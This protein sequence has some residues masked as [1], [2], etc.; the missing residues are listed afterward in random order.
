MLFL[1]CEKKEGKGDIYNKTCEETFPHVHLCYKRWVPA[2]RVNILLP[3]HTH[4][5]WTDFLLIRILRS[6]VLQ[7]QPCAV[8]WGIKA[9]YTHSNSLVYAYEI[10]THL[11][12]NLFCES[13][14]QRGWLIKL[15]CKRHVVLCWVGL[16]GPLCD[17]NV[18]TGG[19]DAV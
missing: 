9:T 1:S 12:L 7:T 5:L 19:S 8:N 17:D 4:S 11:C 18:F 6:K 13:K 16:M 3:F 10:F 15:R 2:L 14:S